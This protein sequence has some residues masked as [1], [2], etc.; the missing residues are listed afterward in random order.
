MFDR[1]DICSAYY[2]FA[3]LF[4]QGQWS[5]TYRIFG[6]LNKIGW[7]PSLLLSGPSDLS[8]NALLIFEQL[9]RNNKCDVMA[10]AGA[11][12]AVEH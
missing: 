12:L 8:E 1:H 10:L 2:M 6:R 3:L 7:R 4:H 11:L 9:V 5:S